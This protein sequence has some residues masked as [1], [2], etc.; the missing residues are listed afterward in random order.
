MRDVYNAQMLVTQNDAQK[1]SLASWRTFVCVTKTHRMS[2]QTQLKAISTKMD[3]SG[4]A[5]IIAKIRLLP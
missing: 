1:S 5:A 4:Q 2:K 3:A